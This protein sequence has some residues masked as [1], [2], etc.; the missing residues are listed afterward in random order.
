MRKYRPFTKPL[1]TQWRFHL[2]ICPYLSIQFSFLL[3]H[4]QMSTEIVDTSLMN[5]CVRTR[6][7]FIKSFN[8]V[9]E[10]STTPFQLADKP[11]DLL[12]FFK[13]LAD[14]SRLLL[15]ILPSN[16]RMNSKS[17]ALLIGGQLGEFELL[18]CVQSENQTTNLGR[19]VWRW[20]PRGENQTVWEFSSY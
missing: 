13:N 4:C 6:L 11:Q 1:F 9:H 17:R 8:D 7:E 10:K 5:V 2:A 12:L 3:W 16:Y 14:I 19:I 15:F 18:K 20:F